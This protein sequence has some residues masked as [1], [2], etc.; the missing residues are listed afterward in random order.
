MGEDA[1]VEVE[2]V[3]FA[4]GEN[5]SEVLVLFPEFMTI[6]SSLSSS[7]MV[8]WCDCLLRAETSGTVIVEDPTATGLTGRDPRS[9]SSR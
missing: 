3:E 1:E 8:S 5:G 4:E 7:T 6:R 9:S 2:R